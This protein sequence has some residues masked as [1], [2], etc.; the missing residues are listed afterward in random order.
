LFLFTIPMLCIPLT[1][2]CL[3]V[4]GIFWWGAFILYVLILYV[5]IRI[6]KANFRFPLVVLVEAVALGYWIVF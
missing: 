2:M 5:L 6:V 4:A 1:F 3:F